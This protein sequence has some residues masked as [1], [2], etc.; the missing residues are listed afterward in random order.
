MEQGQQYLASWDVE[1]A[2]KTYESV[3]SIC[4]EYDADIPERMIALEKLYKLHNQLAHDLSDPGHE[5]KAKQYLTK[6]AEAGGNTD[7]LTTQI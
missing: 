6:H 7:Q 4:E 5:I 1:N 3:V 2:I